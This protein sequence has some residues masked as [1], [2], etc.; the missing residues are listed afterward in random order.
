MQSKLVRDSFFRMHNKFTG[1]IERRRLAKTS[2]KANEIV[3]KPNSDCS[4]VLNSV[5]SVANR[6][7]SLYNI[8]VPII[9]Q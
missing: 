6:V 8:L 1:E 4:S 9:R 3:G 5:H 2:I 7:E